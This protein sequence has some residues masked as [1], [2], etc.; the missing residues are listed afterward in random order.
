MRALRNEP[1]RVLEL[2]EQLFHGSF[3]ALVQRGSEKHV[4]TMLFLTYPSDD[5]IYQL[6]VFTRSE[7]VLDFLL[8][9][10]AIQLSV[11][12]TALWPRLLDIVEAGRCEATVDPGQPHGIKLRRSM[13]LGM[14][15]K[16]GPQET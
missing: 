15:G 12:G 1:A 8:R 16:Y 6:P 5:G 10:G 14:V 11:A 9:A 4:G 2:Y 13:I 3:V 7:F